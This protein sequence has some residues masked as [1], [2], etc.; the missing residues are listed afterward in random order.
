MTTAILW[1]RRDLRV[2]DHAALQAALHAHRRILPI[3]IHALDEEAPWAPG[4]ASRWWLHQSLAALDSALTQRGAALHYYRGRTLPILQQLIRDSGACAIYWQRQYEP[5]AI[6]RDTRIKAAL[7]DAGIHAESHGGTLLFEPWQLQT[8]AGNPYRVFTP[9]WRA[10]QSG[11]ETLSPPLPAPHHVPAATAPGGVPL[12]ALE[13]LPRL[14]WA[15]GF[16]AH[17]TPGEAGALLQLENFATDAAAYALQRDYPARAMTSRLSPHLHFG[18]LTPR[19]I[20]WRLRELGLPLPSA[21]A[22]GENSN[23]APTGPYGAA[24]EPLTESLAEPAAARADAGTGQSAPT[25]DLAAAA[26]TPATP[27]DHAGVA[28]YLR[29]LG[30]REFAH[31]LLYHYP[32]SSEEPLD[33]RFAELPVRE[34][35][36]AA[37]DW[38]AWQHGNTGI[39]IV[40]A[41]L[42]ELWQSGWMHNR[43]RMLAASLLCKNLLLPWQ[44]GARWFWDTLVDA[45]LANNILGWQWTAGCGADAAPY[46]RIFNPVLQGEKFDPDGAYVRR[47][48]PELAHAPAQWIHA[49][50]RAPDDARRRGYPAPI[51]DLALSRQRALDAYARLRK[52]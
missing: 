23:A 50:W 46:F 42:R 29:E 39:P 52:T 1:F 33:P 31:H 17:W 7:R 28:A 22:A 45:D 25:A 43:V 38:Q 49:P 27:A 2:H 26:V 15:D 3:Y 41:G 19:Q 13:L 4:A 32:Q 51:V 5:A 10:A 8:A 14:A 20:V 11:L 34:L 16:K 24:A 12:A 48:I 40:D 47:W 18:E 35:S 6:A 21:G 37:A 44:D 30:W 9:F 36:A